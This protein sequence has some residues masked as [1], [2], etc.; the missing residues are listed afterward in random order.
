M[1]LPLARHLL[2][3]GYWSEELRRV[4]DKLLRAARRVDRRTVELPALGDARGR[5]VLSYILDPILGGDVDHSHTHFWESLHM[6]TALQR[7]GLT[8]EAVHWTNTRYVPEGDVDLLIDVRFNLERWAPIHPRATKVIHLDTCHHEFNNAAQK[9]RHDLLEERRGRRLRPVKLM[10]ETHG[11]ETCDLATYLGNE[12]TRASYDFAGKPM[13]RIPVSVPCRYD[14]LERDWESARRRFLWLGS[15]GLV[16]KGLDLVLEV[17]ARLPELHLTVCGPISRERDFERLYARELYALPNVETLGWVDVTAPSFLAL[18]RRTG[19]L[20][21]PSCAE[22]GGASALTCMHAGLIP[23][24]TREA[25]VDLDA[26]RGITLADDGIDTLSE[27][28]VALSER[29]ATDLESLSRAAWEWVRAHH[30]REIFAA[31]YDTFA[32]ELV[33]AL[34]RTV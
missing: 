28:V 31:R 16:H 25:S 27:A 33:A 12:V 1:P 22:G 30:S 18:A 23:V 13:T 10:P 2:R 32:D 19:A 17:F 7:R 26:G 20:V 15:G 34:Q 21:Y 3:P 4:A 14:W 9:R 24:L 29:S 8:V 6:A 11:I 5:A